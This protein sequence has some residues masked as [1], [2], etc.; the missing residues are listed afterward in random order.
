MALANKALISPVQALNPAFV[1]A[2]E[3]QGLPFGVDAQ[4]QRQTSTVKQKQANAKREYSKQGFKIGSFKFMINYEDA[5]ELT[6]LPDIFSIPNA[7]VWFLGFANI[8]GMLVPVFDLK[9]YFEQ[10]GVGSVT[11]QA[12]NSIAKP[13]LLVLSYQENATGII[14]EGLP[15]RLRFSEEQEVDIGTAPAPLVK[16]VYANYLIDDV[17][18]FDLDVQSLLQMIEQSLKAQ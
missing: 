12:D 14:I 11:E 9:Q 10:T 16:N 2:K 13:M 15:Q 5:S 4:T 3:Q 17:I 1:L 18:W 6:Q 7:P 8:H